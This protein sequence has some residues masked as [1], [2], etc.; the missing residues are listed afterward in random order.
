VEPAQPG[1]KTCGLAEA[2]VEAVERLPDGERILPVLARHRVR[3]LGRKAQQLDGRQL[4]LELGA[5][6]REQKRPAEQ[7]T[8][9]GVQ[10]AAML[11]ERRLRADFGQRVS[12]VERRDEAPQQIHGHLGECG[13]AAAVP[14]EQ[15]RLVGGEIEPHVGIRSHD[16]GWPQPE[17]ARGRKFRV[18]QKHP[19]GVA[20]L[21]LL[22]RPDLLLA[23]GCLE[24]LRHERRHAGN[25]KSPP[26]FRIPAL[27][28]RVLER[29]TIAPAYAGNSSNTLEC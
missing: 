11:G 28:L 2:S 4:P 15:S 3:R 26:G 14:V 7:S 27:V 9:E 29:A 16:V 13:Q 25:C 12:A 5:A 1:C 23:G 8:D 24:D 6:A 21:P 17:S 20:P 22:K 19:R 18:A 10:E